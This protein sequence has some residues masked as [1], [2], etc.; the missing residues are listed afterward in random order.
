[1][2]HRTAYRAAESTLKSLV[3]ELAEE[4]SKRRQ[5]KGTF[6][7]DASFWIHI[8]DDPFVDLDRMEDHWLVLSGDVH[9]D[10]LSSP[11]W[12][13]DFL[14]R[15]IVTWP[16][17]SELA[18]KITAAQMVAGRRRKFNSCAFRYDFSLRPLIKIHC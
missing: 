16:Q 17:V 2:E 8:D 5:F 13:R 14:Q 7:L 11:M 6:M 15:Q 12:L 10:A 18:N 9:W 4:Q 3:R 1:M